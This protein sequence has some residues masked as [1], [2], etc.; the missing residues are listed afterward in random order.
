MPLPAKFHQL[1]SRLDRFFAGEC[2]CEESGAPV[3]VLSALTRAGV[4]P[5]LE[6]ARLARLPRKVATLELAQVIAGFAPGNRLSPEVLRLSERLVRRL[7]KQD[8]A[9][10][11]ASLGHGRYATVIF[12]WPIGLFFLAL[13]AL[14]CL[15]LSHG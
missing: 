15:G 7:P 6:G 5:W 12:L 8:A 1:D 11:L 14:L 2:G 13:V 10:R 9:H 4:D 3:S